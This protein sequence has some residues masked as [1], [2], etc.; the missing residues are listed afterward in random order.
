M[1]SRYMRPLAQFCSQWL[2]SLEFLDVNMSRAV[3]TGLAD[4]LS[5]V[6]RRAFVEK[7]ETAPRHAAG[8]YITLHD[9]P[10]FQFSPDAKR[11]SHPTNRLHP[12]QNAA[13]SHKRGPKRSTHILNSELITNVNPIIF[14]CRSLLSIPFH[15]STIVLSP[16]SPSFIG[17]PWPLLRND[18]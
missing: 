16:S 11:L 5:R 10:P 17:S 14:N 15:T 3:P 13:S 1:K 4:V 8:D 7:N 12:P 9:S 18:I 2:R 6:D